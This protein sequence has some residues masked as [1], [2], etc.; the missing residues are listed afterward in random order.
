M[1]IFLLDWTFG[2]FHK[3]ST[4]IFMLNQLE[5]STPTKKGNRGF[6]RRNPKYKDFQWIC[7]KNPSYVTFICSYCN[8][9][10]KVFDTG[11]MFGLQY[12]LLKDEEDHS[13]FK[14]TFVNYMN[15]CG[16]LILDGT[17]DQ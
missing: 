10:G 17:F 3:N 1:Q 6:V 11:K 13:L 2:S 14:K 9:K 16:N 7:W 12:G 8:L 15:Q 4:P 5:Q